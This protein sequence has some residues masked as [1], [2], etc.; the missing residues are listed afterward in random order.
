MQ[1]AVVDSKPVQA[2]K[3]APHI[4]KCLYCGK[5]VSLTIYMPDNPSAYRSAYAY[6]HASDEVANECQKLRDKEQAELDKVLN[7]R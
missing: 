2:G 6:I 3:D 7:V 5:M 4:A 1:F